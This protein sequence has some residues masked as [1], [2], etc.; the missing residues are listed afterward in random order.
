MHDIL[1]RLWLAS[2]D[3]ETRDETDS[4]DDDGEGGGGLPA[5]VEPPRPSRWPPR[6]RLFLPPALP[7]PCP[8][9]V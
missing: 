9:G 1:F 6:I 8:V 4:G 5:P 7:V 2:Q 3:A